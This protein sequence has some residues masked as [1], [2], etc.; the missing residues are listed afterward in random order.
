MP[1]RPNTCDDAERS[2]RLPDLIQAFARARLQEPHFPLSLLLSR[3]RAYRAYKANHAL[4]SPNPIQR[5]FI[6]ESRIRPPTQG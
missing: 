2:R 5:Y 3:A 6:P 4:S 1:I